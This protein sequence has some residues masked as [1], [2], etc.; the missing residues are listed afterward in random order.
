[1]TDHSSNKDFH[2][3]IDDAI[4]NLFIPSGGGGATVP[5]PA[6]PTPAPPTQSTAPMTQAA[7]QANGGTDV[8][9]AMDEALLSLDWEI[10]A[11]N[12]TRARSCLQAIRQTQPE[13]APASL[14]ELFQLMDTLL[15]AMSEA[16]QSLPTSAPKLL[17]EGL[18][19]LQAVAGAEDMAL[20]EQTI[21]D[22]TLSELR[23]VA[24]ATGPKDYSKLLGVG[25]A[26]APSATP[27]PAM[28]A[29]TP[30]SPNPAATPTQA[31]TQPLPPGLIDTV[32][33][34]LA[35]VGKCISKRIVPLENLFA[36]NPGYEKL[37]AIVSELRE[38][39][40][41]Q[42]QALIQALGPDHCQVAAPA[43]PPSPR[44]TSQYPPWR[45]LVRATWNGT[46]VCFLPEQ[47]AY[48]GDPPNRK[49]GAF[50]PLKYLKKGFFGKLR[51]LLSGPLAVHS[52]ATLKGL[53]VPVAMPP[54]T[55]G[56][57]Q[58]S[59]HLLI[60]CKGNSCMAFWTDS[61]S[62]SMEIDGS[63]TWNPSQS[64]DT[65]LAGTL[66]CRGQAFPVL[67]VRGV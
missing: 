27:A 16:P 51:P 61:P 55:N 66:I 58:V 36:K 53:S 32:N 23:S 34:H 24:P 67:T 52:E 65:L 31:Q 10:S 37:H 30:P 6:S 14:Q 3:E 49:D 45:T 42:Q 57:P 8:F 60:L 47:L 7:P 4:D 59:S 43:D 17:R 29:P 5:S 13:S 41:E 19:T 18:R 20:I 54:N 21:I 56:I 9:A 62:E 28:A 40:E 63:A 46:P 1:M 33:T 22:P 11:A 2:S 25:G 26:S 64:A 12:V 39:L 48:E 35:V 50:F 38:R 44:Q 15:V